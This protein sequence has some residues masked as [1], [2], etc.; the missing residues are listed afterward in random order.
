MGVALGLG[1][2]LGVRCAGEG[3]PAILAI[4]VA[5]MAVISMMTDRAVRTLALIAVLGCVAGAIVGTVN[6]PGSPPRLRE[7]IDRPITAQATSDPHT[8]TEGVTVHMRWVAPDGHR[9]M[10]RAFLPPAPVVARGDTVRLTGEVRDADATTYFARTVTVIAPA[11]G[12]EKYRRDAR[13]YLTTTVRRYVPGAPGDLALGLLIGD[14]SGLPQQRTAD[15][16]A[17]GLSHITAVSGWNVTLVT[18]AIGTVFLA[19]RLRGWRWSLVQF[20]GLAGYVWIV[21]ADP[22]VLR[23]A[24]MGTAALIAV[25]L[26]RPAHSAS[27]LVL[28]AALMVAISPGALETLSFQLSVLATFALIVAMQIAPP[29]DGWRSLVLTPTVTCAAIGLATAPLLAT[30]FGTITLAAIPAN[31]LVAPL[32]PIATIGAIL[33][34]P[35]AATGVGEIAG[36]VTWVCCEVVLRLAALFANA[37]LGQWRVRRF[38]LEAALTSYA[39]LFAVAVAVMP[40][41]RLIARRT[42]RWMRSEPRVAL[43]A[44]LALSGTL[45]SA[46]LAG[47]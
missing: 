7:P 10:S 16:R 32:I 24:I 30:T 27:V 46:A 2:I 1:I 13:S 19:L 8:S 31:V 18:A 41:G 37:P 6:A 28:S 17:A 4:A 9:R 36:T 29:W 47:V 26:G 43:V 38:P 39:A 35:T 21:G 23:A 3:N 5:C 45:L 22:P 44:T 42:S 34:I 14:D 33:V 15:L 25:R 20:A 11:T 40:E 12:L